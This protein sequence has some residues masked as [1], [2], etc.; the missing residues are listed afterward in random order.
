[1]LESF[2]HPDAAEGITSFVERRPPRFQ[3]LDPA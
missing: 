2:A 1:M 3:P